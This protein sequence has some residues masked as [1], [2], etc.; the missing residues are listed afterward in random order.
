MLSLMFS[1]LY[2]GT[3]IVL[4]ANDSG[5]GSFRSAVD[6]ANQGDT[7]RFSPSLIASGSNTINLFSR[8]EFTKS[9][10]I[11]GLYNATDTLF[12]S[13]RN[14]VGILG[15]LYSTSGVS[16]IVFDSLV[17]INAN[18][19][20]NGGAIRINGVVDSTRILNCV[21]RN[22]KATG[23]G[24]GVYSLT[25][26][27]D[28]CNTSF[29]NNEATTEGGAIYSSAPSL[30]IINS[31]IFRCK[32][33]KG[34]GLAGQTHIEI[35]S[36]IIDNNTSIN[37][38]GAIHLV[39]P[40][41]GSPF[42]PFTFLSLSINN[43]ELTNNLSNINGGALFMA[44][45][46]NVC[47]INNSNVSNN[48]S[49]SKGGGLH[50][51]T[52]SK[53]TS[54][55][56][57]NCIIDSNVS[58]N[59]GGGIYCYSAGF[60]TLKLNQTKI[61]RNFSS[62]NGGGIYSFSNYKDSIIVSDC[63]VNYNNASGNS[64]GS[65]IYSETIS[66][67]NSHSFI[68]I[69]KG[70]FNGN[71]CHFGSVISSKSINSS[72]LFENALS[73][74]NNSAGGNFSVIYSAPSLSGG[75]SFGEIKINNSEI[76]NNNT[77]GVYAFSDSV[78]L[79]IDSSV[80]SGNNKGAVFSNGCVIISN[81]TISYNNSFTDGG[82]VYGKDSVFVY[83][84]TINNNFSSRNGGAILGDFI[85]IEKTTIVGN[86][87]SGHG[88][89]LHGNTLNLTNTTLAR[90]YSARVIDCGQ[91]TIKSSVIIMNSSYIP[92]HN[93]ISYTAPMSSG[94]NNIFGQSVILGASLTDSLG[95]HPVSLN[96]DSLRFN[97]GLT[98]TCVPLSPSIAI[99]QG[100]FLDSSAAQNRPI[101]GRRDIGAAE[102]NCQITKADTAVI[103]SGSTGY[104]WRGK[105]YDSTNIYRD[106]IIM[107]SG[108]DS[109][110]LLNLKVTKKTVSTLP[111]LVCNGNYTSPSGK[112]F[113]LSGSYYDT[114]PN[115]QGCDSV[116]TII[117][118]IRNI[119]K[120][121]SKTGGIN[122]TSN[123]SGAT[124]QW[125]DCTNGYSVIPGEINQ[126]YTASSNG[127]YAVRI[128]K[129]GCSI[130][131]N[132]DSV[133]S[134]DQVENVKNSNF[135]IFPNPTIRLLNIEFEGEGNYNILSV[136]GKQVL[137]NGRLQANITTVDISD[138]NT[139][140]YILRVI[141]DEGRVIIK[142]LIKQ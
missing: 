38:G 42:T 74:N 14:S 20:N 103:C 18:S 113:T 48:K 126:T 60:T 134:V 92:S 78:R 47:K 116:I 1:N 8:I 111:V 44:S 81:S 2:S 62:G 41:L 15:T 94:G 80:I 23:K 114:L 109:V 32:A 21:L 36:S 122:L 95:V 76:I 46:S 13:G 115:H 63:N 107:P 56:L 57:L 72:I 58:N 133:F 6:S 45:D 52:T 64:Y 28:I 96:L 30:R 73:K 29:I 102:Y 121:L 27:L 130:V 120:T 54:I 67:P 99:N 88:G 98:K 22:C 39:V 93:T 35:D 123:E 31:A 65:A 108:C 11:K 25:T 79:S 49:L 37:N 3:E 19:F 135:K 85:N 71:F 68:K 82:G 83:K 26:K 97:G 124:Y 33:D 142:R 4:N 138:L 55:E 75:T 112:I 117:L 105:M 17:L 69:N 118:T 34:A 43:S 10:V 106:I 61:T 119:N 50:F 104:M 131:S 9:L 87:Q 125:L 12:I 66:D 16:L 137:R 100:N 84:S 141:T 132:C 128:N 91:L 136:D 5:L 90:N 86:N 127:R 24:G 139:G 53:N 140:M 110:Y 51:F 59:Y 70:T 101:V 77:G 89:I 40:N 7:I 129:N